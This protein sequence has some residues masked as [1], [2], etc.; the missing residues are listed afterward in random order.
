MSRATTEAPV[1]VGKRDVDRGATFFQVDQFVLRNVFTTSDLCEKQRGFLAATMIEKHRDGRAES[2]F[3][4]V[5][6]DNP[7]AAVPA[8]DYAVGRDADD[9]V[10]RHVHDALQG[11]E[12]ELYSG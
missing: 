12:F 9:G 6:V 10:A 1:I 4:G 7:G 8:H 2:F 5:A 11:R 3:R